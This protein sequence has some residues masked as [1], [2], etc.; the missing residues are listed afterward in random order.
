[1]GTLYRVRWNRHR[2]CGV[3]GIGVLT[4]GAIEAAAEIAQ[5]QSQQD[6]AE[7]ESRRLEV[8]VEV[9]RFEAARAQRQ[10]DAVDPDNRLVAGELEARWNKALEKF[11]GLQK[12][13][14]EESSRNGT[15]EPIS[16]VLPRTLAEDLDRVWNSATT[17]I[18]LEK[19]IARTLIE[20]IIADISPE[21]SMI[22]MVIHWKEECTLSCVARRRRGQSMQATSSD[23]VDTIRVLAK[24]C[25]DEHIAQ[26]LNR[27]GAK[28]AKDLVWTRSERL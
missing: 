12:R 28:T 10:Y 24:V 5:Q 18:R 3:A 8:E 11:N 13:L 15:C 4:P 14:E 17:D 21:G 22:E 6:K 26:A 16:P 27:S 1:M 23:A 7:L 2:R 9:A 19:R 25:T 20:E